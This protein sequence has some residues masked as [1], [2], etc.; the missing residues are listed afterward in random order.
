[1]TVSDELDIDDVNARTGRLVL[2]RAGEV[3]ATE[4]SEPVFPLLMLVRTSNEVPVICNVE[5]PVEPTS[6]L[7]LVGAVEACGGCAVIGSRL[8]E[9]LTND[10]ETTIVDPSVALLEARAKELAMVNEEAVELTELVCSRVL[11]AL[12]DSAVVAGT[13]LCKTEELA[14]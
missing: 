13:V 12:D 2:R 11:A 7:L 10:F 4:S 1:V 9:R 6:W 5:A 3:E 14:L 8:D